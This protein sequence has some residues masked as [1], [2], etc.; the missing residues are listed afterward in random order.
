MSNVGNKQKLIEQLRAEANFDR[1]KVSV[2]CKDLIKY[3]QDHE[4]GDVLVVGWDKFHIDNPFKEKQL[5][6]ML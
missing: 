3:C 1:M 5:C 2:A 6:V 4:S